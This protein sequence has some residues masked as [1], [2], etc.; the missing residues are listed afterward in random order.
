MNVTFSVKPEELIQNIV[1]NSL[2]QLSVFLT[3]DIYHFNDKLHGVDSEEKLE[4][5]QKEFNE[6]KESNENGPATL[7]DVLITSI[8]LYITPEILENFVKE[9]E[10]LDV[11]SSTTSIE[12]RVQTFKVLEGYLAKKTFETTFDNHKGFIS[13][14]CKK[15]K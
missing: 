15:L 11:V 4:E 10:T 13:I 9:N 7:D 1:N 12:N 3:Q 8:K 5:I 6:F 2:E 14:L